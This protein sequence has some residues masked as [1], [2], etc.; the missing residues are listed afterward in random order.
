MIEQHTADPPS[1]ATFGLTPKD[2]ETLEQRER[3]LESPAL[4]WSVIAFVGAGGAII[5]YEHRDLVVGAV[6]GLFAGGFVSAIVVELLR[7]ARSLVD[8]RVKRL[9]HFKVAVVA[10]ETARK[11]REESEL[12]KSG[13]FWR[14]LSG[15]EFERE[16]TKLFQRC[17]YRASCTPGSGD[18]G[19]DIVLFH[20]NDRTTAVQCKQT[21]HPVGP[22]A[23]RDLF[24]AMRHAGATE[25]ILATTAGATKAV[26]KFCEGKPLRVMDLREIVEMQNRCD[27]Q[28]PLV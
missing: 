8:P 6:V 20:E 21:Q 25:G 1:L 19:I 2:K 4:W 9:V 24:G 12:R 11:A 15:H 13:V 22:A 16:L 3:F 7:S 18:H 14:S 17:G 26:H 27:S 28:R 23:I 10:F 5:G